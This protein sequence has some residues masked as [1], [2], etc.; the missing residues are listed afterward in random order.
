MVIKSILMIYLLIMVTMDII[1][2]RK[3]II[4]NPEHRGDMVSGFALEAPLYIMS[5]FFIVSL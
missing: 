4:N 1:V 2:T 3:F 5:W